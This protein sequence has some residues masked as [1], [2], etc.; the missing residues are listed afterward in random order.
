[1]CH[2]HRKYYIYLAIADRFSGDRGN[3]RARLGAMV[4]ARRPS[5]QKLAFW[6]RL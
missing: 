1:V 4:P 6:D 2:K 3:G 5:R